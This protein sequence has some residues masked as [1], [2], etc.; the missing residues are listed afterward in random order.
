MTNA[1]HLSSFRLDSTH[2]G[3][4]LFR[5]LH[6]TKQYT[7]NRAMK[8][9]AKTHTAEHIKCLKCPITFK[10]IS[11]YN[12]HNKGRHGGG[13]V[14]PCGIKNN[15]QERCHHTKRNVPIARRFCLKKG[16]RS[17]PL[18]PKYQRLKSKLPHYTMQTSRIIQDK[19]F[20][21]LFLFFCNF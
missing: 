13:Y 4:G 12:Q 11:E 5:C 9:H 1:M 10:T 2:T 16:K 15:G 20:K 18:L 8:A 19:H 6:Y 7:T 14:L 21:F 3:K 17:W